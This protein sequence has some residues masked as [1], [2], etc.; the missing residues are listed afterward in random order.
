[1]T[2]EELTALRPT[3]R[4]RYIEM[5]A[6]VAVAALND[7]ELGITSDLVLVGRVALAE[8]LEEVRLLWC[9]LAA[10]ERKEPA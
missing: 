8:L 1:M 2:D 6:A 3:L 4:D 5:T 7:I 9:D 10:H